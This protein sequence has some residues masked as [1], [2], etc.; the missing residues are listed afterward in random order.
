[1]VDALHRAAGMLRP[2]GVILD[3]HPFDAGYLK[4]GDASLRRG[5]GQANDGERIG[6]LV[7]ESAWQRHARADAAVG[8]AV[9]SGA[10][11]R[12]GAREFLF[13]HYGDSVDE[14]CAFVA[15]KSTDSRFSPET[16][17]QARRAH[18]ARPDAALWLEERARMT[19]LTP[20]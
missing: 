2:S 12:D 16:I 17:D 11:T 8:T 6:I 9:A 15:E 10:L 7:A 4:I 18:A 1:M 3:L 20:P 14:L 13:R 5:S 19:K